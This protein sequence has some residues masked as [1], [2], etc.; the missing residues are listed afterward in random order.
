MKNQSNVYPKDPSCP[1]CYPIPIGLSPERWVK[2]QANHDAGHPNS[3]DHHTSNQDTSLSKETLIE[4]AAKNVTDALSGDP[5][6]F[7]TYRS[8]SSS[9]LTVEGIM[10]SLRYLLED[11]HVNILLE[12][13]GY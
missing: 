7:P 9:E 5:K 11:A 6:D 3:R 12:G 13:T 1:I 2:I 8:L 4:D 10:L